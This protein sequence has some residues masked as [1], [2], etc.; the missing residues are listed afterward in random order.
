MSETISLRVPTE[1]MLKLLNAEWTGVSATYMNKTGTVLA[2]DPAANVSGPSSFLVRQECLQVV[3]QSHGLAVC[4]IIQ[5]EKFDAEVEPNYR[6]N[7]RRSF[8]GL[9]V[10]DGMKLTGS[11]SF[12]EVELSDEDS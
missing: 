9:Y 2:F 4:W 12:G 7:A 6:I 8:H 11:Y 3:L 1:K 10:W 5:G